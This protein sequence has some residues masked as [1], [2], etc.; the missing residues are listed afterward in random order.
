MEAILFALVAHVGWG[1]GDIFGAMA[2]R[3]MGGYSITFWAYIIRVPLLALYIPFDM[4]NVRAITPGNFLLSGLLAI[5]MLIGG[6]LFFEA[7]QGTN[8]SLVGTIGSSFIV[9]TVIL[10]VIFFQESLNFYQVLAII[11]IVVGIVVTSLDFA[12]LRQQ[13]RVM[14]RGV[15][16][17][18]ISALCMGLYF[19]FIRVPI[20]EI[21]WFLPTYISFLFA[22]CLL[23]V[24]KF[25][26]ITLRSPMTGG[27]LLPFLGMVLLVTAA[28]FGYNLGISSGYTSIVAPIAGAYPVLF[29]TLSALVFKESLKR[30]QLW[31]IVLS[32]VGI[33]SLSFLS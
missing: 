2:S 30:Q 14:D 26:R 24:M 18:L 12:S 5:I 31:G 29:V 3:K 7:F 9:P 28:N 20:E 10:S 8:V 27:A 19:A 15:V 6:A 25:Q 4:E 16:L 23:L 22:P 13:G 33:V 11:V 17:A 1:T 32:L 21:G